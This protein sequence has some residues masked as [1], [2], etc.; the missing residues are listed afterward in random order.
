MT[1][2]RPGLDFYLLC[3]PICVS[4]RLLHVWQTYIIHLFDEAD[5][6]VFVILTKQSCSVYRYI[7]EFPLLVSSWWLQLGLY[8]FR[9]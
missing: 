6:S 9:F 1:K 3:E 2:S 7:T 4:L 5:E 8:V